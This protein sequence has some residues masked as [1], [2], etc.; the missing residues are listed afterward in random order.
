[1]EK[2]TKQ[3]VNNII[4]DIIKSFKEEAKI[5]KE[6]QKLELERNKKADIFFKK[7]NEQKDIYFKTGEITQK[8]WAILKK[9]AKKP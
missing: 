4:N 6:I 8:L 3:A 1:M 7:Q 9:E 2:E 5:E